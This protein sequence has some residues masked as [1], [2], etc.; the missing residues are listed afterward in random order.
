MTWTPVQKLS[1]GAG[2]AL[3][4]LA[5]F[6]VVAFATVSRLATQEASVGDASA[7]IATIDQ[8]VVAHA[9]MERAGTE[10]MLTGSDAAH[11]AFAQA[12]IR[13][14]DALDILRVRSEDRP[15][16]RAALDSLGPLLGERFARLNEGIAIRR[17]EGA[18]RAAEFER[19]DAARPSRVGIL[20]LIQ[21][22]RDE[23]SRVLGERTRLQAERG[24]AA[25]TIILVGSLLAFLLAAIAFTPVRPGM[26]ARLTRRLTTPTGMPSIAEFGESGRES[27]RLAGDRLARL[28]QLAFA[29]D[30]PQT[31][32]QV[33][34]AIIT[35]GLGGVS[36]AATV[37]ARHDNGSWLVVARRAS[38]F[39]VGSALPADVARPLA[40][41][42]RHNEP[43][44][45]ESRAER[46]KLYGELPG[47]GARG[48]TA[49]IAVP[50]T[51]HG[52]AS[53]GLLVAFDGPRVFGDDER[54]Y[55]TTLG[56]L[57][58]QAMHRI[59]QSG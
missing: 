59:Q 28:Q 17:R 14:E 7:A 3:L 43:I 45:V 13:V 56:R 46:E 48:E 6:G 57:G 47:L 40:D 9:E 18:E 31:A 50:L 21:R 15:R 49:F 30:T 41:A 51:A 20:P 42:A 52:T 35:R 44:V 11:D 8:L 19:A 58:G 54:A 12:R 10:F 5:L 16:Q 36:S 27:E 24:R 53:G 29:L 55:L 2:M 33:G 34:D 4:V 39:A 22:M 26:A 32:E 23:E 1:I 25:G 38:R 37:I